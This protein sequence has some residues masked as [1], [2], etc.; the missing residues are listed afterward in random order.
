MPNDE[1]QTFLV[2]GVRTVGV[3]NG[4]ARV[5]FFQLNSEG[6][7]TPVLELA[8]PMLQARP[9]ADAFAKVAAS[10]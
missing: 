5:Q 3:H 1:V 2:D 7:P 6:K 9:I 8:I 4:V 10:K